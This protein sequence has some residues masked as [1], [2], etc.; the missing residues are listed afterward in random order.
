MVMF[1]KKGDRNKK[2]VIFFNDR[3]FFLF[4]LYRIFYF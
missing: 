4:Y 3:K 2:I 1:D